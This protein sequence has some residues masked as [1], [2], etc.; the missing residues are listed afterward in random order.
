MTVYQDRIALAEFVGLTAK[1]TIQTI[2]SIGARVCFGQDVL[3][4]NIGSHFLAVEFH[5]EATPLPTVF[6]ASPS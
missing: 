5:P 4:V 6:G 1:V 3:D 2:S